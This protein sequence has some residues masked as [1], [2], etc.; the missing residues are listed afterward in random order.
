MRTS[1][2]EHPGSVLPGGPVG[3]YQW[4]AV[5]RQPS[6]LS[7]RAAGG[8]ARLPVLK[9][10]SL[11]PLTGDSMQPL[12][13]IKL[14][15]SDVIA[16]LAL[17]VSSI[18]LFQ[19]CEANSPRVE[20][21]TEPPFTAEFTDST[22][23]HSQFFAYHRVII[24]NT[25]GRSVTLL[26]LVPDPNMGPLLAVDNDSVST[27]VPPVAL[28]RVREAPDSIFRDPMILRA[29]RDEGFAGLYVMN[30]VI[31]PGEAIVLQLGVRIGGYIRGVPPVDMVL[32][33][34]V[35][36]FSDGSEVD[37]RQAYTLSHE[38]RAEQTW[39]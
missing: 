25:G 22:I 24:T 27:S 19:T 11:G 7:A 15:G 28:F 10:V 13:K 36:V 4:L 2:L 16:L 18:A 33:A 6:M 23:G 5:D 32:L 37:L 9:P 29:Y 21:A 31:P 38:L 35:L 20:V 26:R 8:G 1:G 3:D 12:R 39:R 34:A 14:G 17:V 30:E